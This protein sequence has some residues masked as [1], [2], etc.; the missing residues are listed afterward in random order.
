M[1]VG[2]RVTGGVALLER[3]MEGVFEA[4]APADRLG[5]GESV[6]VVLSL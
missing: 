4:L 2:V 3:E 6:G 5:V 1:G